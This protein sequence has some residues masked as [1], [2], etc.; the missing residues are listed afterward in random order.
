MKTEIIKLGSKESLGLYA[1]DL[2]AELST[3]FIQS[4]G[5]F[6][7]A[8]SG[9]STP[10]VLYQKLVDLHSDD[11]YWN[12]IDFFWS[13]ERYVPFD[14]ENSNGGLAFRRLLSPLEIEKERYFPVLTTEHDP[15]YAALQ[16]E[17]TLRRYFNAPTGVPSFDLIFLGLGDDGHTA[18]LFP[19]TKALRESEKLVAAN[20]ID[21][22]ETWR[23]TFTYPLL[24][25]AKKVIFLVSGPDKAKAAKSIIKDGDRAFPATLVK[26]HQG[27]LLWLLDEQ[28]A[29][30]L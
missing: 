21:K 22:F 16:Y 27:Q 5:R 8:L 1:A 7:V 17:Q 2:F 26:P 30:E 13:D 6:N 19:G 23:I 12:Y 15:H 14:H 29:S 20:W 4:K 28:A 25:N 18:S 11:I 10:A 3:E 9:G 24:N